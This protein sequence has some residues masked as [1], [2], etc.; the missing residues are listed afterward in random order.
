M[1]KQGEITNKQWLEKKP[2]SNDFQKEKKKTTSNDFLKEKKPTS[3]DFLKE[4]KI[5][6]R[7]HSSR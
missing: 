7:I 2:T 6:L 3:N 4:K 5:I 1:Y